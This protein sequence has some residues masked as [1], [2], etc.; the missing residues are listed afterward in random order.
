M[1]PILETSATASCGTSGIILMCLFSF[2]MFLKSYYCIIGLF[3]IA[4]KEGEF[5]KEQIGVTL[6]D[7][8]QRSFKTKRI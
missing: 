3:W 5:Q 1:F 4:N 2:H 7:W 8:A 6:S